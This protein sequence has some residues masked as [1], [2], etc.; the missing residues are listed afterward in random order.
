M[1]M[2]RS[3]TF[4]SKSWIIL[5]LLLLL[6]SS[7]ISH[8]ILID[9][10]VYDPLG[11]LDEAGA[12]LSMDL[13]ASLTSV[14]SGISITGIDLTLSIDAIDIGVTRFGTYTNV[15]G[16]YD[17]GSG[18]V[19]STG[20]VR[21]YNDG[22]NNSPACCN[23][24]D[25]ASFPGERFNGDFGGAATD[26]QEALLDPITGLNP[27]SGEDVNHF[28]VAQLDI[29]FD[30]LS[31]YDSI[32][33]DLVFGFEDFP[34]DDPDGFEFNDSF[35]AYLN[36]VGI[37]L[38]SVISATDAGAAD[39]P[40]TELD[41]VYSQLVASYVC[42]GCSGNKLTLILADAGDSVFDTTVY[43]SGLLERVPPSQVP[44]PGT[45]LLMGSGL[46]GLFGLRKRFV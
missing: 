4:R 19:M 44:E 26:S 25:E 5:S 2:T 7:N 16:T 38:V 9:P 42:D 45:L 30:M 36:D 24:D 8:A 46:L 12:G 28:D 35:G 6:L 20:D 21:S 23:T 32:V 31:G 29:Y 15:S 13:S 37:S 39:I 1:R 33:F 41:G 18:I 43:V 10:I 27:I 22:S 3:S 34:L 14:I 40:G 11:S 17:I